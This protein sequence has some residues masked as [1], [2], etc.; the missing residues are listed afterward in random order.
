MEF[1]ELIEKRYSVRRFLDED[2][3][4]ADLD[5]IIGAAGIAP[6][7]KNYQNWHFVVIKNKDMIHKM[8]DRVTERIQGIASKLEAENARKFLAVGKFSTFF[9]AAPVLVAVFAGKYIPEGYAEL[10]ETKDDQANIDRLLEANPG[11]QGV[12]GAIEQMILASF[13]LGYGA[14]W[15]TSTN[16]TAL[17]MEEIIGF[18]KEGFKLVALVPIGKPDGERRSPVKKNLEE[19]RTMIK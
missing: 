5:K 18:K 17:D 15:M 3:P 14:C 12:G 11:I 2:V 7:G 10:V 1:F 13:N 16:S 6:S 19:I 8:C 9:G 4:D